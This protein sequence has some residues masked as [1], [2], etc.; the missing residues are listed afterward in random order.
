[1]PQSLYPLYLCL[2]LPIAL[3]AN[4][5]R[6]FKFETEYQP[7]SQEIRVLLPDDYNADRTYPVVY[8]LPVERGFGSRWGSPLDVIKSIDAHNKHKAIFVQMGFALEP[9]FG[10]HAEDPR[11][12]QDSYL[13]EFV[14]PFIEKTYSTP[15]TKQGRLLLGFSKSGWGAIS[16]LLKYPN[17]F[18]YAASWDAP[19]MFDRFRYSMKSVYGTQEQLDKYRPDLLA[20][21]NASEFTDTPRI[22]LTGEDL[23]SSDV[24]RFHAH[25]NELGIQHHYDISQRVRHR[26]DAKWVEPSLNALI[27]L[28][29]KR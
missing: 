22:V 17:F 14:V 5:V 23:W 6:S 12:R 25:L 27:D 10:D 21:R 19:M 1:M 24:R 7:G 3:H 18:G 4:E 11:A 16:L 26:W 13:R 28:S 29:Q 15:G 8:V 9:W 20:K 2:L